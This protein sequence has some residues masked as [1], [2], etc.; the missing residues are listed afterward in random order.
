[1]N[2]NLLYK[3]Y[4]DTEKKY[5]DLNEKI[6]ESII[7]QYK[8]N[9]RCCKYG[10]SYFDFLLYTYFYLKKKNKHKEL[11]DILNKYNINYRISIQ[12]AIYDLLLNKK[13]N[14]FM[15]WDD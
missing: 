12:Y 8:S 14:C 4:L 1:M 9:G 3:Y 10:D 15:S 11:K 2:N 7:S 5:L 13:K 6:A